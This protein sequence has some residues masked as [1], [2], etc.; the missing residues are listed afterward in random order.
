MQLIATVAVP[1]LL[2]D[3]SLRACIAGLRNQT[4]T[5]FETIIVD[6][7]GRDLARKLEVETVRIISMPANAG[8]GAAVNRAFEQS[9]APYLITLNDDAVPCPGWLAAMVAA[10]ES[11]LRVGMCASQ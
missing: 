11:D 9:S 8:F 7:S 1:T 6:N 5:D 2:A 4:R 3:T 10:A